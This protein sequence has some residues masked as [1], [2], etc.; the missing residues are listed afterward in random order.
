[1]RYIEI[2][3]ENVLNGPGLRIVLWVSGCEHYCYNCQNVETWNYNYGKE[4]SNIEKEEI[5]N[6]LSK[7]YISGITFSGGD[8][9]YL[10][11]V[12]GVL[13]LISEIKEKFPTKNIWLYTGYL[14][15]EIMNTA[16]TDE[17]DEKNI[18]K[19][20]RKD[21]VSLCDVLVDGPYIDTLKDMTLKFRGSN[22]QRVIDVQK[23][24]KQNKVVLWEP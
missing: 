21:A 22:N 15:E 1:M 2:E 18:H 7:E 24:L 13:N 6:E 23:S 20:E 9:L 19:L 10:K 14:Y 4:F 3:K 16:I 8:P 12:N 5:F 11:N 17:L